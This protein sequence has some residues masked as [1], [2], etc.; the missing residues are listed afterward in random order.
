[1]QASLTGHYVW[2]VLPWLFIAASAGIVRLARW[3]RR[4][5]LTWVVV[6]A[7][8]VLADN[9]ALQRLRTTRVTPEARAVRQALASVP[10]TTG[11]VVVAQANLI[12]HLPYS[13]QMF[14][15]GDAGV[16]PP[17]RPTYVVLT[18]VGSHWP[19]TRDQVQAEI[20]RYKRDP[21]YV[22]VASG[23]VHIFAQRKP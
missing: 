13:P 10:M 3:S 15:A 7:A 4:A 5:S 18:E 12:P 23:P 2:P 16:Q 21:T 22:L 1:M 6:L 17:G 8:V 20:E 11:A 19:M 9:P 14:A